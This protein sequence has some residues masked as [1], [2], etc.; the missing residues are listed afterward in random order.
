ME[1]HLVPTYRQSLNYIQLSQHCFHH[2]I[3]FLWVLPRFPSD[4]RRRFFG[5]I[6]KSSEYR[7]GSRQLQNRPTRQPECVL[8]AFDRICPTIGWETGQMMKM[9]FAIRLWEPF[10]TFRRTES[11]IG[12]SG[13]KMHSKFQYRM[14]EE[15][16]ALYRSAYA[17]LKL[18]L[19]FDMGSQE[20]MRLSKYEQS[21]YSLLSRDPYCVL[22]LERCWN[23][24]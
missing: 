4:R 17:I 3:I 12:R 23:P 16:D 10:T 9:T 1:Q 5:Q 7:Q 14:Q 13:A 18:N 22:A 19:K 24:K 20:R 8:E 21:S 11:R 15:S 6:F 2:S